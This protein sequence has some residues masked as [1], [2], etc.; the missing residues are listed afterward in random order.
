LRSAEPKK[1]KPGFAQSCSNTLQDVDA[2]IGLGSALTR[3]GAWKEALTVLL[4]AE[5]SAG[6]KLGL[7]RRARPRLP[8]RRRRSSCA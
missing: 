1:P 8:A 2:R 5:S 3:R 6:R 7:V 4:E